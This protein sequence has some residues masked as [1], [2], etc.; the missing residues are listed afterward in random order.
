MQPARSYNWNETAESSDSAVIESGQHQNIWVFYHLFVGNSTLSQSIALEQL[1][2]LKAAGIIQRMTGM[3]HTVIGQ[4]FASF[5][6]PMDVNSKRS[7]ASGES[8]NESVTMQL[9]WSHC[10]RFPEDV[11]LYVH[12]KGAWHPTAKNIRF[13]RTCMRALMDYCCFRS[14]T[15]GS[16][17]AK[18]CSA[19]LQGYDVCGSRYSP[20]P[21]SHYPGN[22]WW[23]NC[24]YIRHLIQPSKFE[25]AM[26]VMAREV[27]APYRLRGASIG[28]G[29]FAHEHWIGSHPLLRAVDCMP[30]Y[31]TKTYIAGYDMPP[32]NWPVT[33]RDSL[34]SSDM[35]IYL[36]KDP[37]GYYRAAT[38]ATGGADNFASAK[39]E[40]AAKLYGVG[41]SWHNMSRCNVS[42]CRMFGASTVH[43]F[44]FNGLKIFQDL[45]DPSCPYEGENKAEDSKLEHI[46]AHLEIANALPVVTAGV[47]GMVDVAS[48]VHVRLFGEAVTREEVVSMN[49]KAT[50]AQEGLEEAGSVVEG[51]MEILEAGED[52]GESKDRSWESEGDRREVADERGR[53]QGNLL[54]AV[55]EEG[56]RKNGRA[57]RSALGAQ[58]DGATR[59]G[60]LNENEAERTRG[61]IFIHIPQTGGTSIQRWGTENNVDFGGPH[62]NDPFP[63][64]RANIR[65]CVRTAPPPK[66]SW[67]HIGGKCCSPWHIPLHPAENHVKVQTMLCRC[68]AYCIFVA[69]FRVLK[70]DILRHDHGLVGQS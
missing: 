2:A 60:H 14:V 12:S 40:E 10:E 56:T 65:S 68:V 36:E 3:Q 27:Y 41:Y 11:V 26:D 17:P 55:R 6:L 45:C 51:E 19:W 50:R 7:N 21:H 48:E 23:A 33:C 66:D 18:N 70:I 59:L 43:G 13:R 53:D 34:R 1:S 35:Q 57:T 64:G 47:E 46:S 52:G 37:M 62:S 67:N 69:V 16:W 4:G 5:P 58:G 29:R 28:Q 54:G 25:A 32:P 39:L 24:Q 30:F 61:F 15:N 20:A 9:L 44:R 63:Q 22:M 31:R 42:I 38:R 49:G 8:G